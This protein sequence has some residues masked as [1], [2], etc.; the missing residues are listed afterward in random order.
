MKDLIE[1]TG[2]HFFQVPE[3]GQLVEFNRPTVVTHTQ[4]IEAKLAA[5]ALK[6]VAGGLPDTAEDAEFLEHW[7]ENAEIAVDSFLSTLD[8]D[9]E[10]EETLDAETMAA[11]EE[12]LLLLDEDKDF[13]KDGKPKVGPLNDAVEGMKVSGD[14]RDQFWDQR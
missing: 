11:L 4:S 12:G 2:D 3:T 13:Q 7:K 6:L 9:V 5:G 14:I 10:V 1:T 8:V